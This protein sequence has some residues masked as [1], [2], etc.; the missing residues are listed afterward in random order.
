MP[1]LA[2]WYSIQHYYWLGNLLCSKGRTEIG[3]FLGIFCVLTF[4][5]NHL[6]TILGLKK[7]W[8]A[9]GNTLWGWGHVSQDAGYALSQWPGYDLISFI[10]S[11]HAYERQSSEMRVILLL[12]PLVIHQQKVASYHEMLAAVLERVSPNGW[13]SNGKVQS[14]LNW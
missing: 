2:P 7:Q 3:L 9:Q 4:D 6:L 8:Q 10:I 13:R 12:L 11:I 1:Y 5:L 14:S